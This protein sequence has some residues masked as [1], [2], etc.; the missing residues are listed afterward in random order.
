MKYILGFNRLYSIT[1]DG[2]VF[3]HRSNKFLKIGTTNGGYLNTYLY[4]GLG[5]GKCS[6]KVNGKY[7]RKRKIFLIHRLVAAAYL[8]NYDDKLEVNHKDFNKEN[9]NV[10][11]LEM[12]SSK[13]NWKHAFNAGRYDNLFKKGRITSYNRRKLSYK[14]AK[15]IRKLYCFRKTTTIDLAKKYNVSTSLIKNIIHN[16]TYVR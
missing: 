6:I 13:V 14:D 16:K 8:N 7:K 11:N 10:S 1:K 5:Y 4:L 3:S 2:R 15:L 9:N 12:V